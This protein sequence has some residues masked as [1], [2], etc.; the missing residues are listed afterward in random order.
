ALV[1]PERDP[2]AGALTF[3]TSSSSGEEARAAPMRTPARALALDAPP[4]LG[5]V[6]P[7]HATLHVEQWSLALGS[8]ET[9][10]TVAPEIA[11]AAAL[12]MSA[13]PAPRLVRD[14]PRA[15]VVSVFEVAVE[16]GGWEASR[17]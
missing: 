8:G 3:T 12:S 11:F 4:D 10:A 5:D 16:E 15:V 14:G 2:L 9:S 17:R 1:S 6:V 7:T 13:G